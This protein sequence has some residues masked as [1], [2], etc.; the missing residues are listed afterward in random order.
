[1]SPMIYNKLIR[2]NIPLILQQKNIIA[3]THIAD[4][5]EYA[6]KL[7]EKLDEEVK[8]Y[9]KD[10][11]INEMADIFEVISAILEQ[12]KWTIEQVI[13]VQQKKREEKGAFTKKIILEETRE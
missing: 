8:E 6:Q 13:D 5:K 9:T 7:L 10:Q 11:T 3:K 1:M 2:D 4:E 12:Q